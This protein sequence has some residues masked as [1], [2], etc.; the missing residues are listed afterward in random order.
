MISLIGWMFAL[1][2]SVCAIVLTAA[3]GDTNGHMAACAMIVLAFIATAFIENKNLIAAGEPK[4][5]VASSTARYCGLVWA[6]GALSIA[7]TYGVMLQDRWPEWW[8]FFLGFGAA[9]VASIWFANMM[10][11]DGAA[12]KVDEAMIKLGRTL[13][14][15]QIVG[16]IAALVTMFIEGKFPRPVSFADWAGCNIFVFGG[17]AIIAIS[18]N[19]LRGPR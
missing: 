19:A 16:V 15:V 1:T 14:I 12:G 6:W 13:T 11:R 4:S 17:L 2:A 10:A 18:L 9:A 5:I 3:T 8:Q 7:V